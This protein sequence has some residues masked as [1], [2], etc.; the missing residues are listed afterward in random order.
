LPITL[1]RL[2]WIVEPHFS[3]ISRQ[4]KWLSSI[5]HPAYLLGMVT[6]TTKYFGSVC[7][8]RYG[9]FNSSRSITRERCSVNNKP[10]S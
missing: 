1:D 6:Q 3:V 10:N 8:F 7:D 9:D 5:R 4:G 2:L